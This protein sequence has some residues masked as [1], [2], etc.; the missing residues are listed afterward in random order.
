MTIDANGC[1]SLTTLQVVAGFVSWLNILRV[2]AVGGAV[3]CAAILLYRWFGWLLEIFLL[4]PKEVYEVLGYLASAGLVISSMFVSGGN[5]E[6]FILGGSLFFGA[7]LYISSL[8]HS[9]ENKPDR[10]FGILFIAWAAVAILYDDQIIGFLSIAAFV[11]MLGFAADV[12][13]GI[14]YAVGFHDE[15]SLARTTTGGLIVLTAFVL[16]RIFH[17]TLS[18]VNVF[19][20]G[21][22]WCGSF[23]GYLGLLIVSSRWYQGGRNYALMQVVNIVFGVAALAVGSIFGIGPLRG[24]GGTFFVLYLIEKPFEIPVESV[25]AYAAIGMLVSTLVGFG[26]YWAQNHMDVIRPYLLF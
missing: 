21:A 19:E 18:F 15:D 5:K 17:S 23:V 8:I 9:V 6:W 20:A 7:M 4:I 10:F 2:F 14:G 26:V 11:C 13:P 16:A 1:P 25:T 3:V 12:L 24:I 22:F